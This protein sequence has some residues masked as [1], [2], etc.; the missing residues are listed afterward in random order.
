MTSLQEVE[1]Y[2]KMVDAV[3]KGSEDQLA[4]LF[5]QL[6]FEDVPQAREELKLVLGEIVDTYGSA[7]TQGSLDWY[8]E[9]RPSFKKAYTPKPVE[10][11]D[12]VERVDRLSR[13][14]AGLGVEAPGKALRVLSG[15]IGREIQTG[16]R[17]T[18]LRAADLDPSAPRFARVPVGKTCAFCCMLASRG[19]VY[20]SKDLA[21][22]AGHEF[23]DSCNCRIVPDWEHK[24]LPGYH[25][26]D[27][28]KVYLSARRAAVKAGVKEPPGGIIASY[29]RE[30]HPEMFTDGQGVTRPASEFRSRKLEKLAASLDKD[31]DKGEQR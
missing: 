8:E 12:L 10:V 2:D 5:R 20:R 1:A 17:R 3:L 22:G 24:N 16:P 15:A 25:P 11:V 6:N 26:D 18:I 30:G 29:M 27:M 9:L 21:G 23:H 28:Y 4:A 31:K 7:L 14:V 19:W 13:Y